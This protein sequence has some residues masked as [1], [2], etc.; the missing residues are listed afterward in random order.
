MENITVYKMN[1]RNI[2]SIILLLF[3]LEVSG[4]LFIYTPSFF[5]STIVRSKLL[6]GIMGIFFCV[7]AAFF[8]IGH[9]RLL[10]SSN[11]VELYNKGMINNTNL[12]NIGLILWTDISSFKIKKLKKNILIL[13]FVKNEEKYYHNIKNPVTTINLLSY[14]KIY[15]TPF[16]IETKNLFITAEELEDILQ[17][18]IK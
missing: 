18:K 15:K 1:K 9:L 5:T 16:V 4:F 2:I 10:L 14:K 11:G 12:T 8:L 17:D 13:I 7:V 6:I 3:L